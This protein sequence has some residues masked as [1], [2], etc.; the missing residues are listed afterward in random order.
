[1]LEHIR[2]LRVQ[3]KELR[4]ATF[5]T[6]D[7]EVQGATESNEVHTDDKCDSYDNDKQATE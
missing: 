4:G 2:S 7:K 5:H 6:D 3:T 1:M